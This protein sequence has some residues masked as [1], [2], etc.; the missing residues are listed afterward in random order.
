MGSSL[1]TSSGN[2][3]TLLCVFKQKLWVLFGFCI[4]MN[5]VH[6]LDEFLKV[7]SALGDIVVL[8]TRKEYLK[9]FN[10][11]NIRNVHQA[12]LAKEEWAIVEL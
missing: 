12:E 3:K 9:P 6:F 4:G 1:V 5:L 7:G 11:W 8:Y 10:K 2:P